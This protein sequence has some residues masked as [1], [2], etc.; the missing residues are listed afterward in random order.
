[1][2]NN[3]WVEIAEP[4]LLLHN[5]Q[6][7]VIWCPSTVQHEAPQFKYILQLRPL[8][9]IYVEPPVQLYCVHVTPASFVTS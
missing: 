8:V 1:M 7:D 3:Q 2:D 5:I 4:V 9:A 6:T